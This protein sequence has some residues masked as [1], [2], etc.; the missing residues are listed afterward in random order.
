ML[1]D[2]IGQPTKAFTVTLPFQHT[3]HE[4]FQRTGGHFT[5]WGRFLQQM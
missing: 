4:D 3:A 5:A 2:V 1:I